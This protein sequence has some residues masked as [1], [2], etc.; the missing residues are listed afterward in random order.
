MLCINEDYATH[1]FQLN[2][3]C[4]YACFWIIRDQR[5]D[6]SQFVSK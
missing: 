3:L 2:I 1:S 4:H 5:K 6:S